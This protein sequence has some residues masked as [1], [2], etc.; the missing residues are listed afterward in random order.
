MA[1]KW[2]RTQTIKPEVSEKDEE[3]ERKEREEGDKV[4]HLKL[5]SGRV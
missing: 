2:G 5:T 3:E 4:S 1:L